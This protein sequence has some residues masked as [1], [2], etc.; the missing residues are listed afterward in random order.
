MFPHLKIASPPAA[1]NMLLGG[2][3]VGGREGGREE[4]REG[5]REKV[6]ERRK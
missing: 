3:K 5:R 1:V 6:E 4:E 2:R